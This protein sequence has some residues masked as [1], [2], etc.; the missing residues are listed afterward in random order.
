MF[1]PLYIL[2]TDNKQSSQ[3]R[4]NKKTMVNEEK[5]ANIKNKNTH[6]HF[7]QSRNKSD[8]KHK[9]VIWSLSCFF[10]LS[11]SIV[12]LIGSDCPS[13]SR[14]AILVAIETSS[15]SAG[16]R[17]DNVAAMFLR[18]RHSNAGWTQTDN[19]RNSI[20]Y[21]GDCRG[22]GF[23]F[24]W[25]SFIKLFSSNVVKRKLTGALVCFFLLPDKYLHLI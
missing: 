22:P 24:D 17:G 23:R 21:L 1:L 18:G 13:Q 19:K 20:K 6:R 4:I 11:L 5:Q 3:T 25:T 14:D 15:A 8:K 16:Q 12:P 7:W 9:F 10:F 2:Y